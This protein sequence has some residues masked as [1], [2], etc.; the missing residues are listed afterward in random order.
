MHAAYNTARRPSALLDTRQQPHTLSQPFA[1]AQTSSTRQGSMSSY[2]SLGCKQP[3]TQNRRTHA[4]ARTHAH[5]RTHARTHTHTLL[6]ASWGLQ[7][8]VAMAPVFDLLRPAPAARPATCACSRWLDT[9]VA[10]T[11]HRVCSTQASRRKRHSGRRI[12]AGRGR[13]GVCAGGGTVRVPVGRP[14]RAS[15]SG[16]DLVRGRDRRDASALGRARSAAPRTAREAAPQ[17]D[18]R[19][20]SARGVDHQRL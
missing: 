7:L 20:G 19:L 10:R 15:L 8:V 18:V 13:R 12:G 16:R 2:A 6:C 4:V 3:P 11:R 5:A 9:I 1:S 14:R 17:A